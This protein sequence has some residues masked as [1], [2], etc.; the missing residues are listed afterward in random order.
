[1]FTGQPTKQ[2][3]PNTVPS[4]PPRSLLKI[5]KPQP[6]TNKQTQ[7]PNSII[8]NIIYNRLKLKKQAV[9]CVNT[10]SNGKF[11]PPATIINDKRRLKIS[12]VPLNNSNIVGKVRIVVPQNNVKIQGE[13]SCLSQN[14]GKMQGQTSFLPP[15]V[16]I[17]IEQGVETG[18]TDNYL[19]N[20][21][22]FVQDDMFTSCLPLEVNI[23]TEEDVEATDSILPEKSTFIQDKSMLTSFL[24]PEVNIKPEKENKTHTMIEVEVDLLKPIKQ[25]IKEEMADINLKHSVQ[26]VE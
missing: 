6:Q 22:E 23:K 1:M 19:V 3:K 25:E 4:V 7:K 12:S 13:T 8:N 5:T 20:N 17:K 2:V 18:S 14:I 21:S 11:L 16:T 24:P 9:N 10:E 26:N 15:E